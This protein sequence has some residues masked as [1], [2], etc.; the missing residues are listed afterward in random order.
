MSDCCLLP[1]EHFSQLY[2]TVNKTHVD[3]MMMSTLHRPTRL[4]RL[5]C[6]SSQGKKQIADRH[7][8]PIL[9]IR[10]NHAHYLF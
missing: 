4:I 9:H 8:T 1:T 10:S 7:V 5:Y 3:E 6:A 2:Y